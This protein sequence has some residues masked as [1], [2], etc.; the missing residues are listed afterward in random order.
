ML[1]ETIELKESWLCS[2]KKF[3][4]TLSCSIWKIV[5]V[6]NYFHDLVKELGR[7]NVESV[8]EILGTMIKY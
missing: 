1:S 8:T 4:D 6:S 2:D 5:Y 3:V 7:Q